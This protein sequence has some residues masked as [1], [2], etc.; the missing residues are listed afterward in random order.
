MFKV[1]ASGTPQNAIKQLEK[2]EADNGLSKGDTSPLE[3]Q[4]RS[5]L[6]GFARQV[7]GGYEASTPVSITADW[8]GD[9]RS[10]SVH[11]D[12]HAAA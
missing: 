1:T 10:P 3:Q 11:L 5:Q 6:I 8:A 7:V 9:I 4:L 12:I 2:Q